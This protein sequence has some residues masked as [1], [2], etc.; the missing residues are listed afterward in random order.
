[1]LNN[2]ISIPKVLTKN[3][4][5]IIMFNK[6]N[7]VIKK[8][9]EKEKIREDFVLNCQD[10]EEVI[11]LKNNKDCVFLIKENKNYYPIVM[12]TKDDEDTKTMEIQKTFK[13][14]EDKSNIIN[15]IHDFYEKNCVSGFADI[16]MHK[17]QLLTAKALKYMLGNDFIKYQYIDVRNKCKYLILKNDLII[18][19]RPSGSLYDVQ[20]TK[21]IDKWVQQQHENAEHGSIGQSNFQDIILRAKK[22][23]E[24]FDPKNNPYIIPI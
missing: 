22:E 11:G 8:E 15:H 2:I 17:N 7:I 24:D 16:T 13:Y 5:N 10:D 18:P 3:G 9:F 14:E 6:K 23:Y 1:M 4:I 20:I 12:V 21:T 19:V